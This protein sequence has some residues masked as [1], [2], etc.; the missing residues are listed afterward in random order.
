MSITGMS[1]QWVAAQIKQKGDS[2]HSLEKFTG[3]DLGTSEYEE[4]GRCLRFEYLQPLLEGRKCLLSSILQELLFVK[5]VSGYP[6]ARQHF[7]GETDAILQSLQDEDVEWRAAWMI[8]YK[9]LYRCGDFD[10]VPLLKIWGAIGY[11]PLLVLRQY[12]SKQFI[13]TTQGLAQC[14]FAFK[15]DN[16]MKK[17]HEI[18]NAWNQTQRMKR[19]AANPMTTLEY[20]WWWGIRVNGNVPI[21]SQESI[22][23]IKEHLQVIPSELDIIKQDFEKRSLELGKKIKQLEEEK[24]QLGLDVDVQKLE[25]EKMRKGKNKVEEDL[26]CLKI[27]YKKLRLSIRTARLGKTLEQWQKEIKE[28]KIELISGKRYSKMLGFEKML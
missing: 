23:P 6:K 24:M 13:S 22:R 4:K 7:G 2:M 27:D 28:E 18:S 1:K 20:D 9:I 19:F 12:R 15:G 11:V 8:P 16:Y 26:D 3:F 10:W 5:R 21:L 17:V 14:K 25:A